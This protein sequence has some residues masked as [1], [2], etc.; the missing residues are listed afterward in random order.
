MKRIVAPLLLILFIT[1][2]PYSQTFNTI[3]LEFKRTVTHEN[4]KEFTQGTIYYDG[5]K[6]TLK[7]N[8]PLNQW[9]ILEGNHILIYYPDELRAIKIKSNNPTILP[10]FQA[11]AGVVKED[12]GLSAL[13]Y[14]IKKSEVKGDTLFTYWNPPKKVRK[15]LGE[16]I[17]AFE[18]NKFIFTEARN[19]H[20]K[21]VVR[22]TYHNHFLHGATYFPLRIISTQNT[23]NSTTIEDVIFSNPV[24]DRPLPSQVVN[25][26]IPIGTKIEVMEW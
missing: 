9:M 11:F 16:F 21:I 24:F 2:P 25:F 6:T 15:F 26:N 23:N 13:G 7:I 14:V 3:N 18:K 4:T 12:Y 20:G 19:T 1:T 17:L 22:T 10:F 8:K 5:A